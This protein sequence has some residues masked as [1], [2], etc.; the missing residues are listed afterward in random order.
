VD[1]T[2]LADLRAALTLD[3]DAG[4]RRPVTEL[5]R[6]LVPDLDQVPVKRSL[7]KPDLPP[8]DVPVQRLEVPAPRRKPGRNDP[9][10]CGSGK[11]YKHCHMRADRRGI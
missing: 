4:Q 2:V 5:S 10:W 6:E 8:P 1:P 9:C 11:K 3:F 7:E